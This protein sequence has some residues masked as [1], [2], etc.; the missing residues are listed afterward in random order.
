LD[1]SPEAG[2]ESELSSEL[3]AG[4]GARA[5]AGEGEGAGAGEGAGEAA[6]GGAGAAVVPSLGD[7]ECE[8]GAS[9]TGAVGEGVDVCAQ[10]PA[11]AHKT[12]AKA[13]PKSQALSSLKHPNTALQPAIICPRIIISALHLSPAHRFEQ[14]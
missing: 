4:A 12:R 13:E 11:Q 10:A 9:A 1:A 3:G 8:L 6:L 5:G 14:A 7:D 2:A